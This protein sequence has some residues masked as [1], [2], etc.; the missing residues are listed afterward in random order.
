MNNDNNEQEKTLLNSFIKTRTLFAQMIDPR[1]DFW[2]FFLDTKF[3]LLFTPSSRY[4]RL[5]FGDFFRGGTGV[6]VYIVF[7][8]AHWKTSGP[9]W[10]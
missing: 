9:E 4:S 7:A 3:I 1:E 2:F 6:W 5:E 10:T 8:H